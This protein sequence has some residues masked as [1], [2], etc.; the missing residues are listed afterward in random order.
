MHQ[1]KL[2]GVAGS[3]SPQEE[4]E[5]VLFVSALPRADWFMSKTELLRS[6]GPFYHLLL[7]EGHFWSLPEM[8]IHFPGRIS[9]M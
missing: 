5:G 6:K 8:L 2:G 1:A 4:K 7:K 3:S 9:G